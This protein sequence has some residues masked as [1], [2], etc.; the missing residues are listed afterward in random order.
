MSLMSQTCSIK[1]CTSEIL[2]TQS[3]YRII[4][5]ISEADRPCVRKLLPVLFTLLR[6]SDIDDVIAFMPSV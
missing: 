4:D 3:K 2:Y 5:L 1:N 6:I